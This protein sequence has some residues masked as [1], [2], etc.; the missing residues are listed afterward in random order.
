MSEVA[1]NLINAIR[2]GNATDIEAA[3]NAGIAEKISTKLDDMRTNVAQNMFKTV[4]ASVE[5]SPEVTTE[6]TPAAE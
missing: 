2:S 3:F 1:T 4:E 5:A 6:P